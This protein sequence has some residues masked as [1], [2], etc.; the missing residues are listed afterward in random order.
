MTTL[1]TLKHNSSLQV[2]INGTNIL[3]NNLLIYT[4]KQDKNKNILRYP[5]N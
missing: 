5:H 1:S 3:D 4:S 2:E